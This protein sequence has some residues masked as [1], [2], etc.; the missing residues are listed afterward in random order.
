MIFT[1]TPEACS[2]EDRNTLLNLLRGACYVLPFTHHFDSRRILLDVIDQASANIKTKDDA[3]ELVS[4]MFNQTCVVF[5]FPPQTKEELL[6]GFYQ[7]FNHKQ[8]LQLIRA[9][10]IREEDHAKMMALQAEMQTLRHVGDWH[11]R[12]W[13]I[14][15][16]DIVLI[17]CFLIWMVA[18]RLSRIRQT[19]IGRDPIRKGDGASRLIS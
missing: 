19:K 16:A 10:Q 2:E 5:G 1:R 7:K 12:F 8:H 18:R 13:T 14:V 4:R 17:L 3:I 11:G 9:H 6:Q 15:I